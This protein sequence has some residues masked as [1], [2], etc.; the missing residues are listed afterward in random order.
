MKVEC[1]KKLIN[2]LQNMVNEIDDDVDFILKRNAQEGVDLAIK[3]AQ[4]AF[5]KGYWTGNLARMVKD[6]KIAPK[7]YEIV[8]NAHYS[9]YLEYGTRYMNKEPFMFPT[10]LEI[11]QQVNEDLN[12]LLND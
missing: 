6:K 3:N 10:Y 12:R 5:V 11:K 4:K 9:G 2:K 8:S 7:H 1:T